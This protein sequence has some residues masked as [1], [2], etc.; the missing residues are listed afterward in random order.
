MLMKS[1]VEDFFL[2]IKSLRDEISNI[3][4]YER[5]EI[6]LKQILDTYKI[7]SSEDP[8]EAAN[9]YL[10]IARLKA[11]VPFHKAD[12]K[13]WLNFKLSIV[14]SKEYEVFKS[15]PAFVASPARSSIIETL[16]PRVRY[17]CWRM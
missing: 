5:A 14:I 2:S 12:L 8:I 10:D 17:A 9:A 4:D 11:N 3:S 6:G 1:Y 16:M 7:V 15:D 13:E